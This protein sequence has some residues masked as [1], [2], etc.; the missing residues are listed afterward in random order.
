MKIV[1]SITLVDGWIQLVLNRHT[2]IL[3]VFR[4]LQFEQKGAVS[5]VARVI[6]NGE[7]N[8]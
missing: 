8:L 7:R 6:S 5:K 2:N 1:G 3:A 4:V